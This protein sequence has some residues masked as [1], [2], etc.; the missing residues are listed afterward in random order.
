LESNWSPK[1]TPAAG[2]A[3]D[4]YGPSVFPRLRQISTRWTRT[5][6]EQSATDGQ[7]QSRKNPRLESLGLSPLMR[8]RQTT[9]GWPQTP[10]TSHN[11]HITQN[12]PGGLPL[13]SQTA[14]FLAVESVLIPGAGATRAGRPRDIVSNKRTSGPVGSLPRVGRD[15][16]KWTRDSQESRYPGIHLHGIWLGSNF[17]RSPLR[18]QTPRAAGSASR[19]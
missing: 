16:A 6:L 9:V 11:P 8:T 14:R 1:W 5:R 12:P 3:A 13:A 10:Y 4:S 15:T 18:E 2:A 19:S 7:R 17:N